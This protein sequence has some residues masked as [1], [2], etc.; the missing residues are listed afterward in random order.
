MSQLTLNFWSFPGSLSHMECY[1]R[2]SSETITVK[3]MLAV[4][5]LFTFVPFSELDLHFQRL[6]VGR[7]VA[8]NFFEMDYFICGSWCCLTRV[9]RC[10]LQY[11]APKVYY[12]F[13]LKF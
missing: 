6:D 12:S 13:Q 8:V 4:E 3:R 9:D 5:D 10:M 11:F 2:L 1:L 7:V